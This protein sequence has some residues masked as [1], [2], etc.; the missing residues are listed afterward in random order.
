MQRGTRCGRLRSPADRE[1]IMSGIHWVR[2]PFVLAIVVLAVIV[3]AACSGS[4]TSPAGGGVSSVAAG[5]EQAKAGACA[6]LVDA[7]TAVAS[8]QAGQ[9]GEYA[10]KAS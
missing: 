9:T 8:D 10:S 1:G 3:P 6:K 5:L 4:S 7:S 2:R